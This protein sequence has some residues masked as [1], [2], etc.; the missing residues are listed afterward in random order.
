MKKTLTEI[1]AQI[2]TDSYG[3]ITRKNINYVSN[4][5]FYHIAQELLKGNSVTI[6]NFGKFRRTKHNSISFTPADTVKTK[7]KQ[8]NGQ[9]EKIVN[10]DSK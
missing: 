5:C 8:Q 1:T 10:N 9:K 4:N 7:I 2:Y 3:E 6:T